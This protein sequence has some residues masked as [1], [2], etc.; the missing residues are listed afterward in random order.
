MPAIYKGRDSNE[1]KI[2]G[3]ILESRV[4]EKMKETGDDTWKNSIDLTLGHQLGILDET[5][6]VIPIEENVMINLVTLEGWNINSLYESVLYKCEGG[7]TNEVEDEKIQAS[8][9][10]EAQYQAAFC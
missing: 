2:E 6:R 8:Y 1:I 3:I 7:W 5:E 10:Q 4:K 9:N